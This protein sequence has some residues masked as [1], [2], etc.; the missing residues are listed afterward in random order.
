L[1]LINIKPLANLLKIP[2]PLHVGIKDQR[3]RAFI[4]SALASDRSQQ[5]AA[6]PGGAALERR[7]LA[8]VV[9]RRLGQIAQP[10][11][12]IHARD[13]DYAGLDNAAYL[14]RQLGG[15][16]DLT[17]LDD[18]YHM[19]TIDRQRHVVVE[20]TVAFVARIP[21][22]LKAGLERAQGPRIGAALSPSAA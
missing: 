1:R 3:I 15:P 22:V 14:Q 18:S 17:V 7:R 10:A 13:D 20:R 6:T 12:I 4:R 19:V 11:L 8:K 5:P 2:V 9:M 21:G 16:V